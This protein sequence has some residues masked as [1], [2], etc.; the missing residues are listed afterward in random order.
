MTPWTDAVLPSVLSRCVRTPFTRA[1]Q[2]P[3]PQY[4]VQSGVPAPTS[5]HSVVLQDFVQS[6]SKLC[7]L[8][9][10]IVHWWI[11][12]PAMTWALSKR[13]LSFCARKRRSR[14]C[15]H[16]RECR[17]RVYCSKVTSV[18]CHLARRRSSSVHPTYFA[19]G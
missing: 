12:D 7:G 13:W 5:I 16:H 6:T 8:S 1:C 18:L 17:T 9:F 14:N 2:A 4:H 3:P 15:K 19:S 10:V 11:R